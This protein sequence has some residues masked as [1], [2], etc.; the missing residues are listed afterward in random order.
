MNEFRTYADTIRELFPT[1]MTVLKRRGISSFHSKDNMGY[2]DYSEYLEW[3]DGGVYCTFRYNEH[4]DEGYFTSYRDGQKVISKKFDGCIKE[5]I[6]FID[7]FT[8]EDK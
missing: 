8:K 6:D 2:D 1:L 7:G 5:A 4:D 3:E